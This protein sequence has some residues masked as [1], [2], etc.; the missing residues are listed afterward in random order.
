MCALPASSQTVVAYLG[1]LLESGSISAKS[2]QTYLS[3][4][5]DVHNDFEYPPPACEHLVKL[6]RKGY[7]ELQDSSIQPSHG[8]SNRVHVHHRQVRPLTQHF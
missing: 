4:I 5:N 6:A 3:A 8:V 7:A 2:L 1:Y